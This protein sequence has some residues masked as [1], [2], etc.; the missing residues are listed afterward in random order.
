M[1]HLHVLPLSSDMQ[2]REGGGLSFGSLQH[3]ATEIR[4]LKLS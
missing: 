4:L 1:P 2:F 3:V